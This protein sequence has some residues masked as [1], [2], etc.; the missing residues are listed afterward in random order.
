[1]FLCASWHNSGVCFVKEYVLLESHNFYDSIFVSAS[2]LIYILF[3]ARLKALVY[4]MWEC[5]REKA[6][7]KDRDK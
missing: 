1:M 5:Y 7:G 4:L 3:F 6:G 2:V